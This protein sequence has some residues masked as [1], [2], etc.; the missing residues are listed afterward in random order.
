MNVGFKFEF[1]WGDEFYAYQS[2]V[3]GTDQ[4]EGKI[5]NSSPLELVM[6]E[7]GE[8]ETSEMTVSI[9]DSN[10][11]LRSRIA[12]E[13]SSN[14]YGTVVT[15]YDID[16]NTLAKKFLERY[17]YPRDQFITIL[18]D[19]YSEL[20]NVISSKPITVDEYPDANFNSWQLNF[21]RFA[22]HFMRPGAGVKNLLKAP[23]VN[24]TANH[25]YLV[26]VPMNGTQPNSLEKAFNPSGADITGDCTLHWDAVNGYS[27]VSYTGGAL[28]YIQVN[29]RYSES[30]NTAIDILTDVGNKF[31]SDY[32]FDTSN[33]AT[34][35]DDRHYHWTDEVGGTSFYHAQ[36]HYAINTDMTGNDILNELCSALNLEYYI[37]SSNHIVFH[38]IIYTSMTAD[39]TIETNKISSFRNDGLDTDRMVNKVIFN[40]RYNYV[41]GSFDGHSEITK[42]ESFD[43]HKVYRTKEINN[44]LSPQQ[45]ASDSY[46]SF[47]EVTSKYIM[48]EKKDPLRIATITI[49]IGNIGGRVPTEY[50]SFSHPEAID[51]TTRLY[52]IEKILFDF[53]NDMVSMKLRDIQDLTGLT[54]TDRLLLQPNSFIDGS[55]LF[56]DDAICGN[57]FLISSGTTGVLHN[58]AVKKY[59]NSSADAAGGV[60]VSAIGIDRDWLIHSD[61]HDILNQTN[62]TIELWIQFDALG[63]VEGIMNDTDGV[64]DYWFIYKDAANKINFETDEAGAT[65]TITGTTAL[66]INTWYHVVIVGIGTEYGIYIDGAQEVYRNGSMGSTK[67]GNAGFVIMAAQGGAPMNGQM[68]L[69]R[70][71]HSNIFSLAPVVGLTDVYEI[72]YD[73]L[74]DDGSYNSNFILREH[75]GFV[76]QEN[77]DKIII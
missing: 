52:I 49:P 68:A 59:M 17:S 64:T 42:Q 69:V 75:G 7:D 35:M 6:S 45:M 43:R 24:K 65:I 27:Y 18:S 74:K 21:N 44:K 4:Y 47:T 10:K 26:G 40:N 31:F 25:E 55:A 12:D 46:L 66:A 70:I 1:P 2:V 39:E 19:Y 33:I 71:N 73:Y 9:N 77:G 30:D 76:L 67:F 38:T 61:F 34:V 41:D 29:I 56:W 23:Y 20:N 62:W 57:S 28:E 37:D 16:G 32:T 54:T 5:S 22:G 50:I 48:I 60:G 11:I 58:T 51:N 63:A 13:D 36:P 14:V 72:P 3:I 15:M 53:F 8:Y